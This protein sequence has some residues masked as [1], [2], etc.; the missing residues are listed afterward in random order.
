MGFPL[1]SVRGSPLILLAA[2]VY[3]NRRDNPTLANPNFYYAVT[4]GLRN[5]VNGEWGYAK[6]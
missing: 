3:A 4:E 5:M 1:A 6:I 2:V